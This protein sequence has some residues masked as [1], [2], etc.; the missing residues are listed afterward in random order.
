MHNYIL[1][2]N[3]KKALSDSFTRRMH[4]PSR[5]MSGENLSHHGH[6]SHRLIKHDQRENMIIVIRQNCEERD[7][8]L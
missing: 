5:T 2:P 6:T 1:R 7:I 8:I 4:E 3:N